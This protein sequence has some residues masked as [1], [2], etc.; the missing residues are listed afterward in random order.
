MFEFGKTSKEHLLT[1]DKDLKKVFNLVIKRSN[2]DFGISRGYSSPA[3]Q[4][5]L[6]KKGRS[7]VNGKWVISNKGQ[8]VTYK[9]G[10][11]SPS[12][13]NTREA[14]DIY[15]YFPNNKSEAYNKMALSYIAGLVRSVSEELFEKGEITKK[16]VSGMNWDD[17]GD[18]MFDQEFIDYPHFQV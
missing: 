7:L 1:V 2:I 11:T 10:T 15:A 8:V 16:V 6:F 18:F 14:V 13:H 3:E 5:E 4:F 12:K 9:D 17:D